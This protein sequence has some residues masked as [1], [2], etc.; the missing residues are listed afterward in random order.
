[1]L[2]GDGQLGTSLAGLIGDIW[3]SCDVGGSHLEASRHSQPL[4][5]MTPADS[6]EESIVGAGGVLVPPE[7]YM[8]GL[9]ALCDKCPRHD[10][11]SHCKFTLE[12]DHTSPPVHQSAWHFTRCFGHRKREQQW[13]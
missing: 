7:G 12:I 6:A 3:V 9:R 4:H 13:G 1:M 8:E 5:V 10:L 11:V 2:T